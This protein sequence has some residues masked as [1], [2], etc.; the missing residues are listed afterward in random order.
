MED[1]ERP[2]SNRGLRDA[3]FMAQKLKKNNI[4]PDHI[5]SSDANRAKTTALITAE[6]LHFPKNRIEFTSKLYHASPHSLLSEIK[7]TANI[8]EIIFLFGH[9]PGLNDIIDLLGGKLDNL[10]T[11]GQFGFLFKVENW[12]DI[13]QD[14]AEVWFFDFPKN[15]E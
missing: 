15:K 3:P 13:R 2:L 4:F 5:L 6:N 7:R 10:P 11:C 14:N 8:H 9:N 1:H 12:T